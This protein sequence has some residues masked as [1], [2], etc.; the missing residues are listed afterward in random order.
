M[1]VLVSTV[2]NGPAVL[3]GGTSPAP[4]EVTTSQALA[5]MPTT[6]VPERVVVHGGR[7]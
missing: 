5:A 3:V 6:H 1:L 4:Q 2:L 7:R